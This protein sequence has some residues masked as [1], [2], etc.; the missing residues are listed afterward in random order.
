MCAQAC[1]AAAD[2]FADSA[3]V[4]R[5]RSFITDWDLAILNTLSRR[6]HGTNFLGYLDKA[7]TCLGSFTKMLAEHDLIGKDPLPS[8]VALPVRDH[9]CLGGASCMRQ[10]AC[11]SHLTGGRDV[12][13]R[14]WSCLWTGR[15]RCQ[16]C[17]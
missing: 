11:L 2:A 5:P 16:R 7:K 12:Q 13:G 1:S 10:Q 15:P 8:N 3:H 6:F 9:N 17:Q 14:R 4:W